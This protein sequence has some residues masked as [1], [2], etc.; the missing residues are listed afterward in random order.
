MRLEG[1]EIGC[2]APDGHWCT[3]IALNYEG[4]VYELRL[5][6]PV[7]LNLDQPLLNTFYAL[8]DDFHVF[9]QATVTPHPTLEPIRESLGPGPFLSQA[10]AEGWLA[11]HWAPG[12]RVRSAQLI[13]E[14]EAIREGGCGPAPEGYPG[15]VENGMLPMGRAEGIWLFELEPV[16]GSSGETRRVLLDAV[17]GNPV[18]WGSGPVP[19]AGP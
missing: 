12:M 15:P 14:A 16:P 19:P 11:K 8:A 3:R 9:G 7:G 6:Y 4:K 5:T 13:S 1:W 17:T 18:C 2:P 10:E